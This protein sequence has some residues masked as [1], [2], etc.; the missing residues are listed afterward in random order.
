MAKGSHEI[1]DAIH[2]FIRYSSHERRVIDSLPFQRLR[3]IHQLAL[4]FLVY[5]GATHKRFEHSLGVMELAGRAFDVVTAQDNVT[6]VIRKSFPE[7]GDLQARPYWRTVL[8][9]AALCHDIGHLPF[10]HA[11][12]KE[13]LPTGWTHERLTKEFILSSEMQEIWKSMTPP[14]RA[15]DV[16]RLAV[17][18]DKAKELE[19]TQWHELLSELIVGDAF[20]VDRIDYLLRDSLHTGVGYGRFDHHRLIDTLR[21]LP[22]APLAGPDPSTETPALGVERGG[23]HSAEALLWARYFMYSQVYFHHVRC[24]YNIHLRDFLADWLPGGQLPVALEALAEITDDEALAAIRVAA[25][26]PSAKGHE[27]ARRIVKREHFKLLYERQP[28][29]VAKNPDAGEAISTAARAEFGADNVRRERYKPKGAPLD[30]PV[31][32][33]DG[34]SA[35]SISISEMLQ[36]IPVVN[37]DYVFIEPTLREK[38]EVWLAKN[39]DD[40]LEAS[41]KE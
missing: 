24:I 32:G 26:S 16:A 14:L 31:G 5:P 1:R 36:K 34:R 41:A 40:I 38:A 18:P 27:P 21:I 30:F 4:S 22:Q 3:S 23:I 6:D 15:D 13:L 25:K 20:G 33:A 7:I 8:R 19:F 12:E 17:G 35:S 28:A 11:A 10:S 9:M 39:R 29:D 2:V 37:I